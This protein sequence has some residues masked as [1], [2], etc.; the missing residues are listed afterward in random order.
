MH[1]S[2]HNDD[3]GGWSSAWFSLKGSVIDSDSGC[4]QLPGYQWRVH[5]TF[6]YLFCHLTSHIF[7]NI[8]L[9][10][11]NISDISDLGLCPFTCSFMH[12]LKISY[13][14]SVFFFLKISLGFLFNR[15]VMNDEAVVSPAVADGLIE[16]HLNQMSHISRSWRL[17]NTVVVGRKRQKCA[18][19]T[20]SFFSSMKAI[21]FL[22]FSHSPI[23]NW[24][25][26]DQFRG[27]AWPAF[28]LN[29]ATSQPP[30]PVCSAVSVQ[31]PPPCPPCWTPLSS[32]ARLWH[33]GRHF[34]EDGGGPEM[35]NTCELVKT[36][37]LQ[38]LVTVKSRHAQA[39]WV[40]NYLTTSCR[41]EANGLANAW[42]LIC[43]Q[44]S[45]NSICT[46]KDQ[47]LGFNMIILTLR[48]CVGLI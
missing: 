9:D 17:I 25:Q 41:H 7:I 38:P 34:R 3:W 26:H 14:P 36:L 47:I 16:L 46:M 29:T 8:Y 20:L 31:F 33:A 30:C 40:P 43:V 28:L 21:F 42:A 2:K 23:Q 10:E 12:N 19:F 1:G 22:S 15:P 45:M 39:C 6:I 35:W 5:F 18:F 37:N 27:V 48:L 32:A 44:N 11:N 4:P 24:V 13:I